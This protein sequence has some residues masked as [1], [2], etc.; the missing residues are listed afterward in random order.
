MTTVGTQGEEMVPDMLSSAN[1]S[2]N[3]LFCKSADLTG[4][5]KSKG[6]YWNGHTKKVYISDPMFAIPSASIFKKDVGLKNAFSPYKME[7]EMHIFKVV[8]T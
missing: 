7:S 1:S 2:E 6:D 4:W 5:L 8:L 3:N